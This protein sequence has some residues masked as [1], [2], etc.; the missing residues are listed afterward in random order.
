MNPM[1]FLQIKKK[2]DTFKNNHPKFISFMQNVG[3]EG[4][5]EGSVLEI[6]VTSPEGA[7]HTANIRVTADDMELLNTIRD[8]QM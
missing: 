3:R 8:L 4:I 6:T 2:I 5:R 1:D 7:S